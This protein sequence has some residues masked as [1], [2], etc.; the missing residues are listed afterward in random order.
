MILEP[1]EL[2]LTFEISP[3]WPTL[4]FQLTKQNSNAVSSEDVIHPRHP[5]CS[6]SSQSV[7]CTVEA[8]I[9]HLIIV[10]SE[11]VNAFPARTVP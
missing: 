9:E 6:S 10:A 2:K 5:I 1:C 11:G 7:S 3:E 8:S 4:V